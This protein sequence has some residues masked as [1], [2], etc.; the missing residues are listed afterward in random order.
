MALRLGP[1]EP[2]A[3]DL[4]SHGCRDTADES[5]ANMPAASGRGSTI[6]PVAC[7]PSFSSPF[8]QDPCGCNQVQNT[9]ASSRQVGGS[10][11]FLHRPCVQLAWQILGQN[12]YGYICS[13]FCIVKVEVKG[14]CRRKKR[15]KGQKTKNLCSGS[16]KN[17]CAWT[18]PAVPCKHRGSYMS[19]DLPPFFPERDCMSCSSS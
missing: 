7:R 18:E 8:L 6:C 4:H 3:Q 2:P 5:L 13:E 16:F 14:A 19:S 11:S 1:E 9:P 15:K 12:G 17:P 10:S